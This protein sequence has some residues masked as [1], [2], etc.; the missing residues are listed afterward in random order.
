MTSK[1]QTQFNTSEFFQKEET[2]TGKSKLNRLNNKERTGDK[3]QQIIQTI[4]H[5]SYKYFR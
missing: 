2:R 4:Y 5:R 3:R 1:Y